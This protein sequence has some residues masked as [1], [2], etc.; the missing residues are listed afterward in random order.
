MYY[1]DYNQLL[2]V[3]QQVVNVSGGGTR[4]LLDQGRIEGILEQVTNDDYYPNME[5]KVAY[6]FFAFNK[7]HCFQ[8]GNKRI[9]LAVCIHFLNTN[10]YLYALRR[11]THEME[12]IAIHVAAGNITRDLLVELIYSIIYENDFS[13]ELKLKYFEAIQNAEAP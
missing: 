7:Y 10:G 9:A 13:E 12:N 8:D 2:D 1:I 6:Y 4:G 11:F 3:Y 5:D